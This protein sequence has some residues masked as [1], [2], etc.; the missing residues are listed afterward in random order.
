MARFHSRSSQSRGRYSP[1][2]AAH[3]PKLTRKARL[4][5]I[6]GE[7]GWK[8]FRGLRALVRPLLRWGREFGRSIRAMAP[9]KAGNG[10]PAAMLL[11][12]FGPFQ[13]ADDAGPGRDKTGGALRWI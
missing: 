1:A 13:D 11:Q 9:V 7:I 6:P 10:R 12:R 2:I 5:I 4:V 8:P 3:Q